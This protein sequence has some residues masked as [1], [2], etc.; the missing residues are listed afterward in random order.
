MF[1]NVSKVVLCDRRSTFKPKSMAGAALH[2]CR[3][4]CFFAN[5]IGRAASSRD[6]FARLG[7]WGP[8]RPKVGPCTVEPKVTKQ[9]LVSQ[10]VQFELFAL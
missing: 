8:C 5:R 6:S 9:Q 4:A 3:V 2:T 10:D 1:H 7:R